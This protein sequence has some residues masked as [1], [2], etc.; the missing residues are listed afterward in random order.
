MSHSHSHNHA[1]EHSHAHGHTHHIDI[2]DF[3]W[4]LIIAALLNFIFVA[5][6]AGAGYYYNSVALWADASHNLS[7]AAS[8]LLALLAFR[9]AK[10]PA[11]SF[12]NFGL[13]KTTLL[14]AFFNSLLL[15]LV[16]IFLTYQSISRFWFISNE[17]FGLETAAVATL[18]IIINSATAFLLMSGNKTDVNMRG[19]YL[20][21]IADAL[22][23]LG[24]LVAGVLIWLTHW[25]WIDAAVSL[26]IIALLA[27]STWALL[28]QSWGLINAGVPDAVDWHK[29][30]QEILQTKGIEKVL[31]LQVWALSSAENM[32]ALK[33]SFQDGLTISQLAD[34]QHKI[35]HLLEHHAIQKSNIEIVFHSQK[36]TCQH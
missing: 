3:S 19:A 32:A 5:V 24:V 21:M 6:E 10:I 1:H 15:F 30:K 23:S 28:A 12:Y 16:L 22:I 36:A 11:N 17:I 2:Q 7:D 14:A 8:L 33:L 34:I 26:L 9:L 35:K 31:E 27:R 25:T 20:H 4:K 18:G 29:L 13:K